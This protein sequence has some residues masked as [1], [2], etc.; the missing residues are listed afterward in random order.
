MIRTAISTDAAAIADIYNHCIRT[1]TITFE[2]V[3]VTAEEMARRIENVAS[4]KLPWFVSEVN[5]RIAGYAYATKWRERSAYRFSAEG[6]IYLHHGETGKG[7]AQPLYRQLIETLR[8]AGLHA[9][10]G[11]IAL[12]N[13]ASVRLHEKLGFEAVAR[14]KQVG[15]K[16]D[17]W[18]DVGYWE[19]ML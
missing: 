2:E 15:R 8:E 13:E 4:A 19:L 3:E 14:F 16:F 10:I 11:G 7:L 1:T 6:T 5:G 12:P 9:V 18:L 17:Q